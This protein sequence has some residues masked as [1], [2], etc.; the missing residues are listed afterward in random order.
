ML[1]FSPPL[2]DKLAVVA[3]DSNILETAIEIIKVIRRDVFTRIMRRRSFY[4]NMGEI[5]SIDPK[6]IRSSP[7]KHTE[8]SDELISRIRLIRASLLGVT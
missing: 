6:Q 3:K 1:K 7:I 8:L 2:A 4:E 5:V